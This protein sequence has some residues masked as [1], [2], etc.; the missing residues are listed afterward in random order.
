MKKPM[1]EK[2]EAM[3]KGEAPMPALLRAPL[4][5]ASLLNRAGM[6]LRRAATPVRVDARVISFGNIT[7]GGTGKTPAV[8]ARAQEEIAAGRRVAVLTRGYGATTP[9]AEPFVVTPGQAPPSGGLLSQYCGDEAALIAARVPEC[10]VV[11]SADR[12]AGARVAVEKHGCDTLLLDDGYQYLRLHRDENILL[13]DATCPF[14]N[15]RIV[16][17]GY[18]REPLGAISRATQIVLTRCDQARDLAALEAELATL[19]PSIPLRRTWHAPTALIRLADGELLPLETLRGLEIRAVCGIGNPASFQALLDSHGALRR[20]SVVLADHATLFF[21]L[22]DD[23]LA[24]VMTEKDAVKLARAPEN[25]YA[26][27][28]DLM[29]WPGQK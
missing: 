1:R 3:L 24:T 23:G 2:V 5:A 28:I 26:V 20:E 9:T 11:K 27:R 7:M 17:A 4:E 25:A 12:V 15:R 6:V 10:T 21:Q 14:G 16:P 13:I 19:A 22:D 8:I 18:L 29:D